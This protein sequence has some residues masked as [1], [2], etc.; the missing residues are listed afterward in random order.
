[1]HN[2]H[3]NRLD[4]STV[5]MDLS[6][7]TAE[8][9]WLLTGQGLGDLLVDNDVDLDAPLG[10]GAEH[11]IQAVLFIARR[12]SSEVELGAQPPVED[13]DALP[14][15]CRSNV[16]NDLAYVGTRGLPSRAT[17]TA[18]KYAAPSTCHLTPPLVGGWKDM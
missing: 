13:V 5:S 16:R 18:Q 4:T 15:L 10:S 6:N 1:M 9:G 12:R 8:A 17:E 14:S 3:E 7:P 11:V 2:I